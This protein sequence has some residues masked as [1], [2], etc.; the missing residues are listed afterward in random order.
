MHACE[1]SLRIRIIANA[2][3]GCKLMVVLGSETYGGQGMD[4]FG[5]LEG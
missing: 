5:T 3:D 2:L 4:A 1:S